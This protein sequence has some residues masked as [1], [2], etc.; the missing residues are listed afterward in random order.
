M[1]IQKH[2]RRTLVLILTVLII[3]GCSVAAYGVWAHYQHRPPAP[4]SSSPQQ[5][6]SKN[7]QTA[8]TC[9]EKLPL[10]IKVGQKLMIAGYAALLPQET[11]PLASAS[12]GGVIIMDQTSAA[13]IQSL[14]SA[15]SISPLI[16]VDQEGGTVQRFTQE[17]ILPGAYD[18]ATTKTPAEAYAAYY[19]DDTYLKSLGFTTNFAP[20]LGVISASP[21]SLPGRMYSSDPATVTNYATQSITASFKAGITPVVKHFPGLG[22][23]T[24]NTDFGSATTAP[25][26]ELQSRDLLP[27]QQL[28]KF[29]SD[30]MVSN[31]IVP[32]LTDGEPAV[33]SPAAVNLLRSYGY[34]KAVLYSDSLTAAA[35]PGSL[36]DAVTKAWQA[37]IDIALIVPNKEDIPGF[38]QYLSTIIESATNAYA[39]GSLDTQALNT[40]VLRILERKG[41]NPCSLAS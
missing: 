33:W 35:I 18:M 25:L 15:F 30:A 4:S 38:L 39:A 3:V 28:A 13:S 21:S 36:S 20:V 19:K 22:S 9:T 34:Q 12:V 8:L 14:K 40:S 1:H 31:A 10:T 11:T 37:G 17:G 5:N 29:S 27:Y 6:A 16:A 41:I 32:G 7:A 26:E 24:Q 2:H 23:T